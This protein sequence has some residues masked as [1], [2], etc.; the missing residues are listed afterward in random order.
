VQEVLL[1]RA[2]A[3]DR[4][5]AHPVVRQREGDGL[6]SLHGDKWALHRRVLKHAFFPDNLNVSAYCS[7]SLLSQLP[8]IFFL[9]STTNGW[10]REGMTRA[11]SS[12]SFLQRLV[13]HVGR[14]VAAMAEKWR[15]KA[16]ASSGGEVEVDVAEWFQAVAEEAITRATF[17]RSYDSGS[18]V[19]GMQ[20]HLMAFASEAFRKVLVPGYRFLPTRKNRLSW[21]LDRE[22]R[23]LL[24]ELIG[25]RSEDAGLVNDSGNGFQDVLG[26]MINYDTSG[27]EK[28]QAIPV[29]ETCW[30]SARRSSSL[31]SRRQPTCLPGPQCSC[32]C[33]RTGKNA[34]AGKS[35]T[36]AATTSFRPRTTCPSSKR[37]RPAPPR[38][39]D[40]REQNRTERKENRQ[41]STNKKRESRRRLSWS[42]SLLARQLFVAGN[43]LVSWSVESKTRAAIFG[44][45]VCVQI[46]FLNNLFCRRSSCYKISFL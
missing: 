31:A 24:V 13:A 28:K 15:T 35:S 38:Q 27:G 33:T 18:A 30:K 14:S 26:L 3:F 5:E 36:S 7:V 37:Y 11:R 42:P 8:L 4:Y 17:G 2:D 43:A 12:S 45:L 39:G 20:A 44:L 34:P 9:S 40:S 23:R 21:G 10:P 32:P 41:D 25:R 46:F 1:T 29:A 6:V 16:T 19:F 22:I